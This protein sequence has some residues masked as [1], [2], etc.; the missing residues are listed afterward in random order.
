M[1]SEVGV[2][3]GATVP[4]GVGTAWVISKQQHPLMELALKRLSSEHRW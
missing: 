4:T 2:V 3:L 1:T